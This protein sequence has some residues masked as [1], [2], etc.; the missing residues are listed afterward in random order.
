MPSSAV[1]REYRKRY[2]HPPDPFAARQRK[3]DDVGKLLTAGDDFARYDQ[4]ATWTGGRGVSIYA[5]ADARL[6]GTDPD[7]IDEPRGVAWVDGAKDLLVWTGQDVLLVSGETGQTRWKLSLGVLPEVDLL[8]QDAPQANINLIQQ[9]DL[10]LMG[11]ARRQNL[12]PVRDRPFVVR[13]IPTADD[14]NPAATSADEST[15]DAAG[16][17]VAN[18]Y[19]A[20]GM[21]LLTT[22]T[23]RVAGVRLDDGSIQWQI[24][25]SARAVDRLAA[26]EDF[27]VIKTADESTAQ[28]LVLDTSTG[29]FL[30]RKLFNV[31]QDEEPVNFALADDGTLAY[32]TEDRIL[33]HDLFDAAADPSLAHPKAIADAAPDKPF[34]N[35]TRP[36]QL[37]IRG[38]TILALTEDGVMLRG[39]SAQTGQLREYTQDSHLAQ[40]L[41]PTGEHTDEAQLAAGDKYIYTWGPSSIAAYN[42]EHPEEYWEPRDLDAPGTARQLLLGKD[43]LVLLSQPPDAAGQPSAWSMSAFSRSLVPGKETESGLRVYQQQLTDPQ[44]I[45]AWQ[46]IASGLCYLSGDH[47]LHLLQ[48]NSNPAPPP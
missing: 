21:A 36:D 46:G 24:R 5:L 20:A 15:S 28:L 18:V 19:P 12:L 41:L 2:Q 33:I 39:Y 30:A 25:P 6:L 1:E 4:L 32:T 23:G 13:S 11:R 14:A 17:S 45:I 27:T 43:Y 34:I 7:V 9:M 10:R 8:A 38:G 44:G 3:I 29:R 35:M 47:T 42:I 31:Q 22:T 48:G 26:N 40:M 37:L 16:E